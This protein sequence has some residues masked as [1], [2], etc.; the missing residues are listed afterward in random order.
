[1]PTVVSRDGIVYM[2]GARAHQALAVKAGG[3]GN[4]TK[5]NLLWTKSVGSNVTSP[6]L[7][8]DHLYWVDDGGI[9]YCLKGKDGEQVYR[10]RLGGG[11]YAS[12]TVADGKI[13]VVTKKDG[14][15]VLAAGPK[16]ERVAHNTLSDDSTFNGSPAVSQEQLL[17]RSDKRLYCIG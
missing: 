14:T 8:G 2:I 5:T 3:K 11:V 6:A 7:H 4:V 15:Y 12:V 9:A 17:L 16:F 13:Y 10:E 1:C